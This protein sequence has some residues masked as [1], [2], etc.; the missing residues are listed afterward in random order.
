MSHQ[1]CPHYQLIL[2]DEALVC[3]KCGKKWLG[4]GMNEDGSYIFGVA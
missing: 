2:K 4:E 1:W 3:S